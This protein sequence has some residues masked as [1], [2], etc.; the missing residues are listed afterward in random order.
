M[1]FSSDLYLYISKSKFNKRDI[2]IN[3][4]KSRNRFDKTILRA[5][6]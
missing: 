2:D 6:L 4:L 5:K 1:I 3:T